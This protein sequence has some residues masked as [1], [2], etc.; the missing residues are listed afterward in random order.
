MGEEEGR[1][2]CGC[3]VEGELPAGPV[4]GERQTG[5]RRDQITHLQLRGRAQQLIKDHGFLLF[6][7]Q[8]PPT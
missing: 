6:P 7:H 5:H 1:L 2:G 4:A 8:H 3:L